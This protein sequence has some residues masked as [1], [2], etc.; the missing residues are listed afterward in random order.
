MPNPLPA[1]PGRTAA[2]G[3]AGEVALVAA[4]TGQCIFAVDISQNLRRLGVIPI[5][6][7]YSELSEYSFPTVFVHLGAEERQALLENR[8]ECPAGTA[9]MSR[10]KSAVKAVPGS[11]FVA[12]DFCAPTDSPRFRYGSGVFSAMA[13]WR[14]LASSAK[15]RQALGQGVERL[16]VRPTRRMDRTR[17]FRLFFFQRQLKAMSQYNLDRHFSRLERRSEELWQLA[18]EFAKPIAGLLPTDTVVVDVYLTSNR[19]FIIVDLNQWGPPTDIKLLKAWDRNWEEPIGLR[20]ISKPVK[21]KGDI[22]VSF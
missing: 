16:V 2:L 8:P 10:L 1:A 9:L 12:T 18:Q 6:Q 13:A 3:S 17:E 20:L 19:K 7:W 4:R 15:V 11:V 5:S 21:M 22:S 14:L